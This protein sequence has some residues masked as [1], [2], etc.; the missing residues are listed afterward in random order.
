MTK[1]VELVEESISSSRSKDF[2]TLGTI[3]GLFI[4]VVISVLLY[5]I[6]ITNQ[7]AESFGLIYFIIAGFI[8]LFTTI[9]FRF[10]FWLLSFAIPSILLISLSGFL[11]YK[12]VEFAKNQP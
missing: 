1:K 3:L 7:I 4:G 6:P 8:C 12:I 10:L 9:L 2:G 5:I 11:I